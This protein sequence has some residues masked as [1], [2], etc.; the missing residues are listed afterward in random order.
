M[1]GELHRLAPAPG[2]L[3]KPFQNFLSAAHPHSVRREPPRGGAMWGRHLAVVTGAEAREGQLSRPP[4]AP[5]SPAH[6]RPALA[7]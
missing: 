2:R 3:L 7:P 1:L 4:R 5:L 6:L